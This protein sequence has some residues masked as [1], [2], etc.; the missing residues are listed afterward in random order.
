MWHLHHAS[1]T[2]QC[3]PIQVVPVGFDAV[4]AQKVH[5]ALYERTGL[6]QLCSTVAPGMMPVQSD[7]MWASQSDMT[8]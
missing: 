5:F 2:S 4:L 8:A 3:L 1:S 6:Q 7:A